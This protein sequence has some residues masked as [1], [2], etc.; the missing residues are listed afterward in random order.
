MTQSPF[1]DLHR[2]TPRIGYIMPWFAG[3]LYGAQVLTGP[4]R[5]A[6]NTVADRLYAIPIYIPQLTTVATIGARVSSGIAGNMRLGL[7][8]DDGGYP[9]DLAFD[10]GDLSTAAAADKTYAAAYVPTYI[11]WH[12]L[13]IVTSAITSMLSHSNSIVPSLLGQDSNTDTVNHA[14]IYAAHAYAALPDPFP[15][16]ATYGAN[17]P[18]DVCLSL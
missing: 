18:P 3:N 12:W 17:Q 13:A 4:S 5:G 15:A 10:S 14:Y 11:G 16:G 8:L 6:V 2:G 9:G 1:L 7:Y